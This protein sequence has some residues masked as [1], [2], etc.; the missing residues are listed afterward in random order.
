MTATDHFQK[1]DRIGHQ[2]DIEILCKI[3]EGGMGEVYEA[4]LK[5]SFG[6]EKKI[7][8][9]VVRTELATGEAVS[10]A[11]AEP[12]DTHQTFLL[13]LIDEAKLV[14]NLIHTHIVQIYF[15][16][17]I[18]SGGRSDGY[19]AMEFVS[20]VNLRSFI[21]RHISEG[22]FIDLDIA[23]YIAS[24]LARALEYAHTRLEAGGEPAGIVHRDISPANVLVSSEGV[25]KLSD[26]GIAQAKHL[27]RFKEGTVVGKR[28]YMSPE[29]MAGAPVDFRTDI[30]S[31]GFVFH[32]LL[33]NRIPSRENALPPP[34][35]LR[36]E[37]PRDID[38]VFARM[39]AGNPLD[40]FSSTREL[41]LVLERIIYGKGYGPTF[42]TLSE[43]LLTLFPALSRTGSQRAGS[44][45]RTLGITQG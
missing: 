40:R 1:K 31:L 16:G 8:L 21:D 28:K 12:S 22:R 38:V 23:V 45:E 25:V 11:V 34:S 20:G 29:Q 2:L 10:A 26:F 13:R 30:F 36:P 3:A 7:A 9:K 15:F 33:T 44:D 14:S 6:F 41:A 5:G 32:E 27:N 17:I 37:L 35:S 19:M 42:V 39:T 43:Y 4:L 18:E 24:R